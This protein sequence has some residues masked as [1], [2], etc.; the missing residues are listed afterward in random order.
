MSGSGEATLAHA[1]P[2]PS[3]P[4]S[5]PFTPGI[6]AAPSSPDA[7]S[8]RLS[9]VDGRKRFLHGRL[10]SFATIP[11]GFA[12][13]RSFLIDDQAKQRKYFICIALS[14]IAVCLFLAWEGSHAIAISYAIAIMAFIGAIM[15]PDLK[16]GCIYNFSS[17]TLGIYILHALVR[18]IVFKYSQDNIDSIIRV[19]IVFVGAAA[20]TLVCKK[21]PWLRNLV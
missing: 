18:D 10:Y 8:S 2:R 16:S 1:P 21:I 6:R 7:K 13:G 17:L 15:I 20:L 3:P 4:S 11:I 19:I 14:T 9:A 12:I 5:P